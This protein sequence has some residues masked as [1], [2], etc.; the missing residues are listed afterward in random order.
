LIDGRKQQDGYIPG[1]GVGRD[2]A[3]NLRAIQARH[4]IVEDDAVDP[5]AK[6]CRSVEE[7]E[8]HFAALS[9][10]AVE[11]PTAKLLQQDVAIDLVVVDHEYPCAGYVDRYRARRLIVFID[12]QRNGEP[13][14]GAF[15]WR[16]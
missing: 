6:R 14:N 2:A 1:S 5:R 4:L 11:M 15:A 13:E 8:A 3:G 10:S 9:R 12:L 7:S 16:T